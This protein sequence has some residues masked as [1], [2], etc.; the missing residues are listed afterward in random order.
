MKVLFTVL[1]VYII[2]CKIWGGGVFLF[3]N[4][5]VISVIKSFE[6]KRKNTLKVFCSSL[7]H[8]LV[9]IIIILIAITLPLVM[10]FLLSELLFGLHS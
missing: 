7:K 5:F 6:I 8:G 1:F 9:F 2:R 3:G 4:S 10:Y